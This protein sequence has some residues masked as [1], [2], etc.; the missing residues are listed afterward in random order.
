MNLNVLLLAR[1]D[2]GLQVL[3]EMAKEGKGFDLGETIQDL[4]EVTAL[5]VRM[6]VRTQT[7]CRNILDSAR[8][9]CYFYY[10]FSICSSEC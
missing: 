7:Y 5:S 8:R 1:G 10:G 4:A 9:E 3:V 6:C 2:V